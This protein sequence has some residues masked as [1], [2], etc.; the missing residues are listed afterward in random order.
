ML[1]KITALLLLSS[2]WTSAAWAQEPQGFFER[3]CRLGEESR[4]QPLITKIKRLLR[5]QDCNDLVEMLRQR[6][7]LYVGGGPLTEP[8]QRGQ[9]QILSEFTQLTSL[10]INLTQTQDLCPL[11]LLPNLRRLIAR[12]NQIANVSCLAQL[13]RLTMLNLGGNQIRRIKP[14]AELSELKQLQLN[15][16]HITTLELSSRNKNLE[17]LNVHRNGLR[18]AS[19]LA[20]LPKL[21]VFK[22]SGNNL[23]GDL[24]AMPQLEQLDL[25][26][27]PLGTITIRAEANW[28]KYLTLART[29]VTDLAPLAALPALR[30]VDLSG[31]GVVSAQLVHLKAWGL[32]RLFLNDNAVDDVSALQNLDRLTMLRLARN[33]LGTSIAKTEANC[34]TTA[35]SPGV[36]SWCA[37]P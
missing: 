3:Q 7:H 8:F 20:L 4:Y 35:R 17:K 26:D 30:W 18:D 16:N 27:N 28:L 1:A 21:K 6:K 5:T 37:E 33:P 13:T 15:D 34:P 10:N 22:A 24:P 23:S 14:L 19:A 11:A 9:L 12:N 32:E 29:G 31:N 2:L 36:A 25:S